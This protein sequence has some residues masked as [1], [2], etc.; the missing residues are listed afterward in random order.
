MAIDTLRGHSVKYGG[1]LGTA[2]KKEEEVNLFGGV[3]KEEIKSVIPV[4]GSYMN[5]ER[6][7]ILHTTDIECKELREYTSQHI[8]NNKSILRNEHAG[9][10]KNW[11]DYAHSFGDVAQ[12]SHMV[13]SLKSL[14]CQKRL[15]VRIGDGGMKNDPVMIGDMKNIYGNGRFCNI[16]FSLE[17]GILPAGEHTFTCDAEQLTENEKAIEGFLKRMSKSNLDFICHDVSRGIEEFINEYD[18]L[19][20]IVPMSF[21]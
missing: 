21:Y 18:S 1:E 20:K 6:N 19:S 12:F 16:S 9:I 13:A 5:P 8:K 4:W 10:L 3:R 14:L 17:K 2:F 7:F 11:R 15:N